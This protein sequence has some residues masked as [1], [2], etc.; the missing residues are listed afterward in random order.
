MMYRLP[1]GLEFATE[2]EVKAY[3]LGAQYA[4]GNAANA[5]E[6]QIENAKLALAEA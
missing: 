5:V 1:N 6:M 3:I 2:A 4:S